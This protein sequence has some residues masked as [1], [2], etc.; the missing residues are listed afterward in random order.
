MRG[1]GLRGIR[2][3]RGGGKYRRGGLSSYHS[4]HHSYNI[5]RREHH[6][7]GDEDSQVK[8]GIERQEFKSRSRGKLF[9]CLTILE[10]YYTLSLGIAI[11]GLFVISSLPKKS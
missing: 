2:G 9:F 7:S 5:E 8:D 1:D 6:E 11:T 4:Y 10:V 3:A